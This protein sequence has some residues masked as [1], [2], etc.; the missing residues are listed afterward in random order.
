MSNS[1]NLYASNDRYKTAADS[2]ILYRK[3][4]KN[5][6]EFD[7]TIVSFLQE[8]API[9]DFFNSLYFQVKE[10]GFLSAKQLECIQKGIDEDNASKAIKNLYKQQAAFLITCVSRG[11]VTFKIDSG[12]SYTMNA[13]GVKFKKGHYCL[14]RYNVTYTDGQLFKI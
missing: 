11:M 8:K 4:A 12:E 2:I 1:T 13:E 5:L 14:V 3:E 7:Q 6:R 9:H 10:K